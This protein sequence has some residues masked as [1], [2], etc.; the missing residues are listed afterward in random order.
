[1]LHWT[2][3]NRCTLNLAIIAGT[4]ALLTFA[5]QAMAA[6]EID[7]W[8]G[9]A[10]VWNGYTSHD[11]QVGDAAC[12]VVVPKKIAEG[13]PW[14]WRARFFGH[15][16]QTD[17]ALLERGFHLVYCNIGGL[18]G[19]PEAVE[20]WNKFYTFL[21]E[22]HK[23]AKRPVLEGM[24]R[25]GLIVLNWAIANPDR[26]SAIY[27]DAPVCDIRSWP[28]GLGSGKGGGGCWPQCL[29]VYKLKA[30]EM[31]DW[32]G[33]PLDN[34]KALAE[35]KVPIISVCG[36]ADDVVPLDENSGILKERYEALGG[37]IKL[38]AKPGVGHHPHSLKDPTPIL[39]FIDK[40]GKP[41]N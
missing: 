6:D 15:Q 34:L 27:I 28:G 7:T 19:A 4:I 5:G 25:G 12:K 37:P 29:G 41:I 9:K 2:T 35:A 21:T 33:G 13:R 1:M 39:E 31:K 18:Y 8:P 10:G 17:L 26:V 16:P 30:D 23:F 3:T 11:F 14:I 36:D 24:S 38:I 32:T 40:Q 20:R 22:E